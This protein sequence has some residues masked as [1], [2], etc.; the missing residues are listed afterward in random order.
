MTILSIFTIFPKKY[1]LEDKNVHTASNVKGTVQ[2]DLYPP[3]ASFFDQRAKIFSI[4]FDFV[5]LCIQIFNWKKT[6]KRIL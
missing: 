4:F 5:K 2:G 1:F 6:V 3:V